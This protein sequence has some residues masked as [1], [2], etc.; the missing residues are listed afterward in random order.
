MAKRRSTTSQPDIRI[1]SD[2]Q[3]SLLR[4]RSIT[5]V[6][7]KPSLFGGQDLLLD[8]LYSIQPLQVGNHPENNPIHNVREVLEGHEKEV[9]LI[10][11]E[12]LHL[13]KD[14]KKS[15]QW[16]Q[17]ARWIKYEQTVE[18]D[19]TRFSKPHVTLLSVIS[20][21]QLKNCLRKGVIL[22]DIEANSFEEVT[23]QLCAAW[24][25]RGMLESE[26]ST[27][28]KDLLRSPKYHLIGNSMRS[29]TE[30]RKAITTF[31]T[32]RLEWNSDVNH[33]INKRLS[34]GEN[35]GEQEESMYDVSLREMK[36]LAEGTEGAAIMSAIF[37]GLD[38]PICAFLRLEKAKVFYPEMPNIPVPLRFVFVLISPHDHYTN[39]TRAIGRTMGA[40][41]SDEIFRKVAHCSLEPYTIADALEEFFVQVVAIPPGNCSTETRWEPN[42]DSDQVARSVGMLYASYDDPFD[43]EPELEHKKEMH[44]DIVRTGR[45]FGGLCDDIKRKAPFFVSDFSDFFRGRWSQSFAAFIFLFFAN[46]TSI[47][48]FGAVMERA[49]HHQM[50]AIE[51]IICGG[52]SGVIF[53]LF[54]GQPLNILSATGP[55]L[56]FETILFD[57]C[58]ANGWEFLPFRFWVA[59]WI[60]VVLLILVATDMSA[61]VGLIT[62]FTEEAFAALISI[63]FIIQSFEKLVEISHDAPIITDPKSVFDSP[64]VC[65]LNESVALGFNS[66]MQQK[67]MDIDA[68][69]CIKRGGEAFGLQ[70][71]F[72]PD[73]YMLSILLT[74]GT[75][76]LA[77]GLNI[78]RRT[79]FLTFT[80][81]NSISDFGVFIAI[82]VMTAVSKF[83]GLDLP[84][85]HIPLNF[86]PTTDRPWLIN[87]LSVDWYVALFAALPAVFYA[88][89]IIMDQQITAVII[90]RKDNKLRKGY[91]YHLDLLVIAVLVVICGSLGLPFY[92]AATVL[93]VMHVD[94]LRLQSDTSAPGEKAQ[95]LGVREQRLTAIIAHLLIGFSVFITPVIKLVPLPVL[96]G[97]FLYMGV[98]SMLGLQF[99]Q[100][101]AMLFMPIKYQPDYVWLRLVRMKRV[102]LFTCI[103]ILSI[104]GLFAV[105]YMPSFSM[106]FP[107]MLVLMVLI[108]MFCLEKIF[109]KQELIA[110]D[111]PVP[112]FHSVVSAKQQYN[113]GIFFLNSILF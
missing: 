7:P 72:K 61:L 105:K 4:R 84:V 20:I 104:V 51:N 78:F 76:A 62:R 66:T 28:I 23:D 53:A 32:D 73:V 102:H 67:L 110:L 101:I 92:V 34:E 6:Y 94:S 24:M 90:N 89:L 69:D 68:E 1:R 45:C 10:Y 82:V 98:V 109:S 100:R 19:G 29:S 38:R 91:G 64:C 86:R 13:E 37:S 56:V 93:S 48:T 27:C 59:V 9:P 5:E 15:K 97:I 99:I 25:E 40:L 63:V 46:I 35:E 47:I 107:L 21:I 2:S 14:G 96:I 77:Y 74:F 80:I 30:I 85:L 103:Q 113:R 17:V 36:K 79:P 55:T 22:L 41:F 31:A 75:F 87:F 54:S 52:I 57:F 33:V 18:G 88:I 16:K 112:S 60:G 12:M 8:P 95:F 83:I 43:E 11:T 26:S 106:M 58:L 50:A 44:N 49:L 108:R 70:C 111:D 65:Y 71:H 42:T 81:R 3:S 39:E